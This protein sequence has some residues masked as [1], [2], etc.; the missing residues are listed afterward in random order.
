MAMLDGDEKNRIL[1]ELV[2]SEWTAYARGEDFDKQSTPQRVFSSVW[3]LEAEVNNGGLSQYFFNSSRFTAPFVIEALVTI[4]A[5]RAADLSR[6]AIQCAFPDGLPGDLNAMRL[7]AANF[8]DAV[9]E[10]LNKLDRE[11]YQY[12]DDLTGLLFDYV[13][14][15]PE[16][17]GDLTDFS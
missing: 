15:H 13:R 7:A 4:G 1:M 5:H 3:A 11:F 10:T 9:E 2:Q 16:E 6:R 12:P 14:T 8:P 17:F